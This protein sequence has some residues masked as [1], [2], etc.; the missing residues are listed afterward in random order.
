ML[1]YILDPHS[2]RH[3][4]AIVRQH[5]RSKSGG[6][7]NTIN[8]YPSSQRQRLKF[9]QRQVI[10]SIFIN[11]GRGR[12]LLNHSGYDSSSC[13]SKMHDWVPMALSSIAFLR[14]YYAHRHPSRTI[15]SWK[16][17]IEHIEFLHCRFLVPLAVP[18]LHYQTFLALSKHNCHCDTC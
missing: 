8:S 7:R 6:Q 2:P 18:T 11:N 13:S 17:S 16:D 1:N 4:G 15:F 12:S 9:R 14:S 10:R 3:H 5:R